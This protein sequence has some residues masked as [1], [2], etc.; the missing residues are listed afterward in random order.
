VRTFGSVEQALAAVV[1]FEDRW[2]VDGRWFRY[3]RYL[4]EG[5]RQLTRA[6]LIVKA[7]RR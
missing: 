4:E 3:L 6:W 7:R 2:R 5:G 1:A